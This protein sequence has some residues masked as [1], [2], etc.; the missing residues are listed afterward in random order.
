MGPSGKGGKAGLVAMVMQ[1]I[2]FNYLWS[3]SF[4]TDAAKPLQIGLA[5]EPYQL[6]IVGP[7]EDTAQTGDL[8]VVNGDIQITGR[9]KVVVAGSP[10]DR[11]FHIWPGA[12]LNLINLVTHAVPRPLRERIYPLDS[13]PFFWTGL[14]PRPARTLQP[15]T[16][17]LC[18]WDASQIIAIP[19]PV[20]GSGLCYVSPVGCN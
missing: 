18:D 7:D 17:L 16:R 9:G 6:S 10:D 2:T 3:G 8:D 12:R 13:L 19:M 14:R 4:R 5:A 1:L 15:W 20:A 11:L